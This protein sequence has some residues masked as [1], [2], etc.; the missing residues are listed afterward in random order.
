MLTDRQFGTAR[1]GAI[2][3]FQSKLSPKGPTYTPLLHVPLGAGE[4]AE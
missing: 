2:T 1:I 4:I 3:L